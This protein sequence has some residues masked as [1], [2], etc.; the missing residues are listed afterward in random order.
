MDTETPQVDLN[1]DGVVDEVEMQNYIKKTEAHRKI[2]YVSLASILV[3]TG[4]LM[5]PLV[6]V[7]R[8]K[9]LSDLFS[10][11]YVMT[12]SIVATFMGVSSWLSKK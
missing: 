1:H 8:V 9:A 3:F 7:D 5:S 2:A 6:D 10:M 12:G 4:F 11:F